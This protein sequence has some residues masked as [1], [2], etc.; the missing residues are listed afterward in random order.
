[1]DVSEQ[2][3]RIDAITWYHDFDFGNGLK[4]QTTVDAEFHRQLWRSI[5]QELD[6]IDF[7]GKSVLDIGCWDG[8]WSFYAERRGAR[9]VLATDDCT[10]NWAGSAG[11]LLAKELYGSSVSVNL[12]LSV[13][14]L[15]SLNQQFDIIL[16]LGVYYHLFDPFYALAQIRHCCHNDTVVLIDGPVALALV[17]ATALFNFADRTCEWLPT[18]GALEQLLRATYF[19]IISPDVPDIRPP[20]PP[21][22]RSK[23]WWLRTVME[24]LKKSRLGI[25]ALAHELEP[26]LPSTLQRR[27]FLKCAPFVGT[28][29]LHYYRPPFGLHKYDSRFCEVSDCHVDKIFFLSDEEFVIAVFKKFLGREPD[30]VGYK[31]YLS[32]IKSGTVRQAVIE[33]IKNS[34]EY[35][36]LSSKRKDEQAS[37]LT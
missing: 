4:A 26:M 31:H 24:M 7:Q 33:A 1:M 14:Q 22:K 21:I 17:P 13:Y 9:T 2:R 35:R 37:N 34:D 10:Q 3:A 12:N 18:L 30:Q 16:F 15:A 20:Q 19:S 25:L 6:A 11:C 8:Y 27:L 28:N 5:K 36:L 32:L 23:H 29:E